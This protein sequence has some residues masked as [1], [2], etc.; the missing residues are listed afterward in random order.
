MFH[1][2]FRGRSAWVA[3]IL[4]VL[5][6]S[7]A[8]AADSGPG[9]PAAVEWPARAPVARPA[10]WAP[11]GPLEQRARALLGRMSL[12]QKIGQ[13]IQAEI[14]SASPED[15]RDY[16]LGSVLNGGGS[17]PG[18]NARATVADWASLADRYYRASMTPDGDRPA[19]PVLWGVDAVHGHN[20]V[21]GAILYPHNI[22]LGAANDPR[23]VEA[24]GAAVAADVRR[25]GIGW[26]FAPTVA[27]VQDARWGRTY[28]GF[29]HDPALVAGLGESFV[30]GLQGAPAASDQLGPD[31]VI[32]TAK[33]F[34]GD[35][36]TDGGTDQGDNTASE[37]TLRDRDAAGYY[38]ALAADVQTVMVSFSSWQGQKLHGSR[39]LITDVL[40]GR[41][42]FDG[43]V[44]SDWNAIS[45]VP[46]CSNASCPAAINAGIDMI[47]APTDWKPLYKTMIDQ[48]RTGV[49][50]MARI[51]DAVLRILRVKLRAGLFEQGAP[52]SLMGKPRETFAARDADRQLAR[53]AVRKSL[54]LLKNQNQIL[55]LRRDIRVMVA[56]AGADNIPMQSGGWSLTWQGTETSNADFPGATSVYRGIAQAV[57]AGGGTAILSPDGSYA[58]PPD[59]AIVV[60]GE[61]PYAEG[62]GD[63]QDL[64]WSTRSPKDLALLRRLKAAGIPVVAVFLSGRPLW[65][66]PEINTSDAFVA[67]WLPGTEGGGVAD[68]L[69]SG[70]GG[71]RLHDFTGRLPFAWPATTMPPKDPATTAFPV[72]YGLSLSATTG[73]MAALSETSGLT[74]VSRRSETVFF[75]R[76][77]LSP[78]RVF[79]GDPM[80]WQTPLTATQA[81]SA[82]NYLAVTKVDHLVQE[83]ALRAVWNG[84]GL[85]QIYLQS[86]GGADWTTLLKTPR[87]LAFSLKINARP[88]TT[89]ILRMDCI[90]PCGASADITRLLKAAPSDQWLRVSVDLACFVKAGLDPRKVETPFLISTQGKLDIAVSYIQLEP[91]GAQRPTINC[92]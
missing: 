62:K 31:R 65:T 45:Q 67:A 76:G 64:G 87:Q 70:P 17:F 84:K 58:T 60:F 68:L 11:D 12:E 27:V 36:G 8:V 46:G 91:V 41:M 39:Y 53:E 80:G 66:S 88:S 55:P 85:A 15:V 44:V 52:S 19:I 26:A 92:S 78:W 10:A 54:V 42:G 86:A 82:S 13:M 21:Y 24:I 83:D 6:V 20:N 29:G 34:I 32:A 9:T 74:Q 57:T 38:S 7:M 37:A 56:G 33:H 16:H 49:I 77:P 90:Y 51:D 25:T 69:F 30:R 48:A 40:K 2:A 3:V 18:G 63:L 1:K 89:T 43:L 79:L 35:G 81:T 75:D 28:E 47:M 14:R 22:G 71:Q 23:M 5:G 4:T 72:G 59:A 61:E 73:A 50:P